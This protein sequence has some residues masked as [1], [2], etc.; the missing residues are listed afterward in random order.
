M[1]YKLLTEALLSGKPYFGLALRAMQGVP[2]RHMYFLPVVSSVVS[3]LARHPGGT[4]EILEIGSWAGGSA[5]TWALAL[6]QTGAAGKVTCVDPWEPYFNTDEDTDKHYRHMN[7]AARAGLISGLFE[8]NIRSAGVAEIVRVRRGASRS[9][10]PGLRAGSFDVVYIDG[11]H[12]F[13]DV[14]FDIQE[15]KRLLRNGGIVCGDDLELETTSLPEDELRNAIA[16]NRDFVYSETVRSHYHP[17]VT[18]AVAEG[19]PAV[20]VWNGFWAVRRSGTEWT[21]PVLDLTALRLPD[22]LQ[23]ASEGCRL[24]DST[25]T[26][27]LVEA[28]GRFF[29]I[30]KALG[31]VELFQEYLGD[32]ELPPVLLAGGSVE[33]VRRKSEGISL[34]T[35][36]AVPVLTG[37]Y[38]GFNLVAHNGRTYAL[39]N[40]LGPVEVTDGEF[41]LERRFGPN[42][43]LFADTV[44][45]VRTRIDIVEIERQL[46]ALTTGLASLGSASESK[47]AR[48]KGELAALRAVLEA[49]T[50]AR[51][52]KITTSIAELRNAFEETRQV[53]Q[54]GFAAAAQQIED[55]LNA[56]DEQLR[57]RDVLEGLRELHAGLAMLTQEVRT[58]ESRLE[59]DLRQ[60]NTMLQ[61]LV[62]D[63]QGRSRSWTN[64][65]LGIFSR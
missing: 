22:H 59:A 53:T 65:L 37:S 17:G 28:A 24:V 58:T 23:A 39:R 4:V 30:A 38:R 20:G 44:D 12:L 5:I 3:G 47:S 52:G 1:S 26:Y 15:A 11:S 57:T 14:R 60:V 55:R 35:T 9:L 62:R 49:E 41:E 8:H 32:R 6:R 13:E 10:L 42:D 63:L 2:E 46:S 19:F 29:A 43:V 7:A 21:P 25:A 61:S 34:P 33:E 54:A 56:L 36:A 31:P 45:A 18:R 64:R 48:R 40:S 16:Q 50:A 27:N 51:D